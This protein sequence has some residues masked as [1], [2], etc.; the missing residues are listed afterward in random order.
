M[1]IEARL[2][3]LGLTLPAPLRPP[4]GL[5]V[6]YVWVRVRKD[7][8]YVAAHPPLNPDGTLAGPFGKVGADVSLAA[9][10]AAARLAGLAMLGSLQRALGDLD[11]VTA[12]LRVCGMVNAA[13]GFTQPAHV[14]NAFSELILELYGPEVGQHARTAVGV[15]ALS[16]D[17]PVV[18]EA[19]VEVSLS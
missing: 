8:A 3:A 15:A 4:D 17:N 1:R 19:E 13:T 14:L 7:R 16:W 6:P 12:W 18:I 10:Q 11:R 9:A 5:A 2:H